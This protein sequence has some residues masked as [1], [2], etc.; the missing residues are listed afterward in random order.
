M[1][2]RLLNFKIMLLHMLMGFILPFQVCA[3]KVSVQA[4]I[5]AHQ[6]TAIHYMEEYGIPA[7]IILGIAIHESAS[8]NSKL[9]RY[10]NNHFGIKGENT[11]TAIRSSYKGYDS[12]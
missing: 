1:R 5:E 3:Q 11:S 6:K 10:L 7:S 4:Y 8:G 12:V 2:M 9:A